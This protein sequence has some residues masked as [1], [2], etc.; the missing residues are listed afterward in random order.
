MDN[1][2][3]CVERPG[4]GKKKKN[5]ELSLRLLFNVAGDGFKSPGKS[6][7]RV[8]FEMPSRDLNNAQGR[9]QY[10]RTVSRL[11][12][13]EEWYQE[14]AVEARETACAVCVSMQTSLCTELQFP[15]VCTANLSPLL[16][17]LSIE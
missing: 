4:H 6:D 2:N 16:R 17:L 10:W 5:Q 1:I 8:R 11:C 14:L 12:V 13:Q 3:M 9:G 7:S 15:A